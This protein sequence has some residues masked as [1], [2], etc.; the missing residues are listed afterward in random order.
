MAIFSKTGKSIQTDICLHPGEV[1][2]DELEEREIKQKDFASDI[3]IP[4]TQL[5][6]IINGKRI[7]SS[8]LAIILEA[9][10]GVS[11]SFWTNLQA[12]FDLAKA[13]SNEKVV[14]RKESVQLWANIK[15]YIN[16]NYLRK[17]NELGDNIESNIEK[18]KLIF[19]IN[20]WNEIESLKERSGIHYFRKSQLLNINQ[21]NLT[22]WINYVKYCAQFEKVDKYNP[23]DI[24]SLLEVLKKIFLKE[25]ILNNTKNALSNYGIKFFAKDKLE[26][27]NV[28]GVTFWSFDNPV[29]VLTLRHNRID[30]FVFT[31]FHELAHIHLHLI[32]NKDIVI[33]DNTEED[34]S[35]EKQIVEDEA[36]EFASN[37]L[38]DKDLWKDFIRKTYRFDDETIINFSQFVEVP[39]AIVRGRLC[40]EKLIPFGKKTNISYKLV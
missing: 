6:E 32:E 25:D 15:Q 2:K 40:K 23:K 8:E 7:V 14:T 37:N 31:L 5:N 3:G 22:T 10:L 18:V 30:N 1:L 36:N 38:I 29:I 13:R 26:G 17:V 28:D 24:Y 27:V 9:A 34:E 12:N 16:V 4:V 11:A 39:P 21:D 19:N 20:D 33:I 35:S